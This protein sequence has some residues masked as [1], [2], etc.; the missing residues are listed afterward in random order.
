MLWSIRGSVQ[1]FATPSFMGKANVTDLLG[2]TDTGVTSC[3]TDAVDSWV[4]GQEV[5]NLRSLACTDD[6]AKGMHP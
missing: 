4:L 3:E 6:Q 2:H 1:A 5:S